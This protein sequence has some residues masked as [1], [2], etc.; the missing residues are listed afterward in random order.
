MIIILLRNHFCDY[1]FIILASANSKDNLFE[2]GEQ[3]ICLGENPKK[4]RTFSFSVEKK[5]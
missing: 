2:L 5:L 1:D 3:F 4:Y